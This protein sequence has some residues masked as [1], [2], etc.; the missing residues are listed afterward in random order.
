M[1]LKHDGEQYRDTYHGDRDVSAHPIL[2]IYAHKLAALAPLGIRDKHL[3][4][5]AG[6]QT[7][8]TTGDYMGIH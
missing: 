4:R 8:K 5:Q 2:M 7:G 6:S 3:I 1:T